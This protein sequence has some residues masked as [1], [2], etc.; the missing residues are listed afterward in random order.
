MSNSAALARCAVPA[1]VRS[2][3]RHIERVTDRS[4]HFM[5]RIMPERARSHSAIRSRTDACEA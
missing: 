2:N 4:A 1:R 5:V 3:T